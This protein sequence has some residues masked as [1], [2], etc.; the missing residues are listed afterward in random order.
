MTFK[1]ARNRKLKRRILP[2]SAAAR[3]IPVGG[4]ASGQ[5]APAVVPDADRSPPRSWRSFFV[6]GWAP[7][8]VVIDA[9]AYCDRTERIERIERIET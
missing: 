4:Q 6:Y 2:T 7:A 5:G 8:E 1:S 3:M 9:S